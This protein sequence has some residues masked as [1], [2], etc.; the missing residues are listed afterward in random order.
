[1]ANKKKLLPEQRAYI[2]QLY[3]WLLPH[4]TF[5]GEQ[6]RKKLSEMFGVSE[7]TIKRCL[8]KRKQ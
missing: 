7:T 3:F 4:T 2:S 6:M 5:T 8:Y 1:M